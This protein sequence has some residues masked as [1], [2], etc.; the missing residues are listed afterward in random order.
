MPL[1][2]ELLQAPAI[3]S[4]RPT[5]GPSQGRRKPVI[6]QSIAPTSEIRHSIPYELPPA[7]NGAGVG[8]VIECKSVGFDDHR[9]RVL[10]QVQRAPEVLRDG[11]LAPDP[12]AG[13]GMLEGELLGMQRLPAN[14]VRRQLRG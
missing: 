14:R 2:V 8:G 13:P 6:H 11:G 12:I 4:V 9:L 1:I 7:R 3:S 10:K 5:I